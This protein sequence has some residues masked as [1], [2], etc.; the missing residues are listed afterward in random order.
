M[1]NKPGFKVSMGSETFLYLII[2]IIVFAFIFF[3]PSIYKFVSDIRTGNLFKNDEPQETLPPTEN[4]EEQE[5]GKV[6]ELDG[7]KTLVCSLTDSKPEGNL[8]EVNTFY[9]TSNKLSSFKETKTYDAITDEYINYVYSE[10]AR[11]KNMN[12]LYKDIDGF[13]YTASLESRMLK[14]TF[15]YDLTKLNTGSLK[16][17][18]ETLT[19]NFYV[20]KDQKL[21]EVKK[22]YTD[23]GYLCK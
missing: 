20:S 18:D 22:I 21:E 3:M 5:E 1:K 9:F 10:Q 13:S 16:N 17:E 15:A 2:G 11:F 14:V 4:K 23:M 8:E 19:I 6:E 7:E 12:S